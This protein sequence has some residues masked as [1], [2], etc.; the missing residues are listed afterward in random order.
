M[1]EAKV[2]GTVN[3]MGLG[4]ETGSVHTHIIL[5]PICNIIYHILDIITILCN[6]WIFSSPNVFH[7]LMNKVGHLIILQYG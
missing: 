4:A 7:S 2:L 6:N 5:G 3:G 1:H